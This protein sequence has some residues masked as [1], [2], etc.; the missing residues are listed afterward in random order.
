ME[1]GTSGTGTS[2]QPQDSEGSGDDVK[3]GKRQ[4]HMPGKPVF[5]SLFR[6]N[7]DI[8]EVARYTIS[9]LVNAPA[10]KIRPLPLF[11]Q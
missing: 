8:P 10:L 4:K 6:N 3:P 1:T 9:L 5:S 7:P 2:V 11:R